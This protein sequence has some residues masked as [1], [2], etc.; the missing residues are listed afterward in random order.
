MA[1]FL[2]LLALALTAGAPAGQFGSSQGVFQ[3]SAF[4]PASSMAA[5]TKPGCAHTNYLIQVGST[6][7]HTSL[8]PMRSFGPAGMLSIGGFHPADIQAAY[9]MN[10]SGGTGVIAIID[11]YN[12]PTALA[13]FNTFS[14]QFGLPQETSSNP[15]ASSNTVFQVVYQGGSAPSTNSGWVGEIA[16][17]IEWAHAMAPNAKIILFEAQ[18]SSLANLSAMAQLA[19]TTYGAN[20]ISM[21]FGASEFSG[22]SSYD[23][24]F[25]TS[26]PTY[27]AAA[28]DVGGERL[29]PA[30]STSVIGVGGTSLTMSGSTVTS[31]TAWSGSGGG[32]SQFLARPSFQD[33]VVSVVGANRGCP[34]VAALADNNTPAAIYTSTDDGFGTGWQQFGGTSLATP[35]VAGITNN[36]QHFASNVG[37]ELSRIYANL[38]SSLYRDIT[39]GSA[40]GHNAVLGYDLVTGIGAPIGYYPSSSVTYT[41]SATAVYSGGTTN[42]NTAG[43]SAA[44][45]NSVYTIATTA[46]SA[47]QNA[48]VQTTYTLP[49]GG[50]SYLSL[51]IDST[52]TSPLLS[53]VQLY[54]YNNTTGKYDLLK[55]QNGTGVSSALNFTI[56]ANLTKYVNSSNKVKVLL[57]SLYPAR[58]KPAAYTF[59]VDQLTLNASS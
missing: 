15:T 23:T 47:G 46:A 36:R 37:A 40:G 41:P 35:I 52:S 6:T 42:G 2:P 57:R 48:T 11:A 19:A 8:P 28:G 33:P 9:Q 26:G 39:S 22:E 58:L 1:S 18:D 31:E 50:A 51:E 49:Q 55:Q 3:G 29:Y 45:D 5:F 13:D 34:D 43:L 4:I 53:T 25:S 44:G 14:S 59:T 12:D 10:A 56:T 38:G 16:L 17:D 32:L 7:S 54:A 21:S 20:Q 27:F 30:M 24:Y